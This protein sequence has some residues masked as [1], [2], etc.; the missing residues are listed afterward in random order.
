MRG[1]LGKG[2]LPLAQF[3][4]RPA[5]TIQLLG[6]CAGIKPHHRRGIA[7]RRLVP[8][9]QPCEQPAFGLFGLGELLHNRLCPWPAQAH[10]SLRR[11]PRALALWPCGVLK[12][13]EEMLGGGLEEEDCAI[14]PPPLQGRGWG[15]GLSIWRSVCGKS[16]PQPLP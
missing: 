5:Q 3:C 15:W 4:T 12:R 6:D 16:P 1:G 13:F 7:R 2:T 10:Q 8:F 9:G 14:I 11:I